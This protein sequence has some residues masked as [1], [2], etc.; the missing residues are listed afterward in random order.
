MWFIINHLPNKI[1]YF[2]TYSIVK[3]KIPNLFQPRDY[4]EYICR[5][6]LL[7]R[8]NSIAFLADKYKVREY[9]QG[10]G[11]G[12]ILTQIYG[13]WDNANKI[14]F[15]PLPDKFALKC[16]HGCGMNIVCHDKSK[17]D[18][19]N[20]IETLNKWL[21]TPHS[22]FFESHYKKIKPLIICEEFITDNSG[23]FP[24]DFKFHCAHGKPIFIQVCFDRNESSVGKRIIFDVNWN[25]LHYI[26]NDDDHFSNIKVSRPKHF[27]EMLQFASLLSSGL[28]YAR[29]DLYDTNERVIF[30]EITLTPMG[31]WLS[32][33]KQEALKVMGEKI[34]NLK[35]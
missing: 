5:D 1:R 10:K 16:N 22:V 35:S 13:V 18:K 7:N 23:V 33:F 29:I 20:T 24:I 28:D 2:I 27:E 11:L 32:Y 17:L 26:I 6:I 15:G 34:R 30:G 9:V 31:G 25:D 21:K 14:D 4:S 3:H 12:S 19:S 8:N